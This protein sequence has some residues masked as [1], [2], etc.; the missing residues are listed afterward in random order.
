MS[1]DSRDPQD[2][3]R[4]SV[5]SIRFAFA[6]GDVEEGLRHILERITDA[7]VAYDRQW[8]FTYLNRRAE[9]YFG[10]TR[11][12]L[13]GKNVW[14]QFPMAVG[15]VY[16]RELQRAVAEQA[17]V[18]FVIPALLSESR[19][20]A[21][22][23][24]PSA[25]GV[26]VYFRDIT[27]QREAEQALRE[28]E[29]RYRSLF[30]NS[31]DGVLL[32][33]LD[34]AILAA[35]P[36]AC[37]MFGLREEE[38]IRLG[39]RGVM[40]LDDAAWPPALAARTRAGRFHGV[41]HFRR[42][43][44]SRFAAEVSSVVFTDAR[45]ATRSSTIL[46]DLT[47]ARRLQREIGL[48]ETRFRRLVESSNE[49]IWATDAEGETDYVN[50]AMAEMVGYRREELMGLRLPDLI[51]D[52]PVRER[53]AAPIG[54][55]EGSWPHVHDGRLRRR[56]GTEVWV[57]M[58]TA[59]L[60]SEAGELLGTLTTVADITD[61]KRAEEDQQLL[62]GQALRAAQDRDE[63][64]GIVS[65]DLRSP[66]HNVLLAAQ[67]ITM[68]T[69][70]P[71]VQVHVQRIRRAAGWASKLIQELLDNA[72]LEAGRLAIERRPYDAA[73]LVGDVIELH[74]PAADEKHVE[75]MAAVDPGLP[76]ILA[77]R[78]RM[79]QVLGNLVDNAI[80][81][82]PPGGRVVVS[83]EPEGAAVRLSVTDTG[84]G[85]PAEAVS[86][87]FER[88]WQAQRR[89]G[90]GAGLGLS[91]A[92]GIVEAHGGAIWVESRAGGGTAFRLTCPRAGG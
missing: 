7:F 69:S 16:H 56:D 46:R 78:D 24:Y 52:A 34:G 6:T 85:I 86:H 13:L 37:R 26:S 11:E 80:R 88:F 75:V 51:V 40:D 1:D 70:D 10:R 20:F 8:R 14:E 31:V 39:C 21:V 19:W 55:R 67:L 82:T 48:Q 29:E 81:H 59:P 25:D 92:K 64:L 17:A 32:T 3:E 62:Y 65:H 36:S 58:S 66:L 18:E 90:S 53:A 91:I 15:S 68:Y 30:A 84:P 23:A 33:S 4:T 27:A 50:R 76:P 49:G 74:R 45:G 44:G 63:I 35:S 5:E 73:V 22:I 87:V 60:V 54:R 42:G 83:A 41:L 2:G 71:R 12:Q 9:G 72:R 28:S 38:L 79:L 47:E 57:Q 89:E 77:D 61:R 43:D